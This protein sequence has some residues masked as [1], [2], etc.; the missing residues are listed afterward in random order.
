MV[1][2]LLLILLLMMIA[3]PLLYRVHWS[4]DAFSVKVQQDGIGR[5]PDFPAPEDGAQ[6]G[7]VALGLNIA[8]D[9]WANSFER[10]VPGQ[11]AVVVPKLG[12]RQVVQ[13]YKVQDGDTLGRI[14]DR[15]N[16]TLEELLFLN[17]RTFPNKDL[18]FTG[19]NM[20]VPQV[21]PPSGAAAAE[22]T[23]EV[24]VTVTV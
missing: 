3:V 15:F 8:E 19:Q 12:S 17:P 23:P 5:T 2:I 18:I 22:V 24:T 13:P 1:L 10:S 21:D 9:I 20:M 7:G 11:G 4:F 16:T 14:A 6:I